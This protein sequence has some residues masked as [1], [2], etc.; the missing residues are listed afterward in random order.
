MVV[1]KSC[2]SNSIISP[3]FA[4]WDSSAMKSFSL[5]LICE[6]FMSSLISY[7]LM[8]IYFIHWLYKPTTIAIQ[9]D[10]P[11]CPDLVSGTMEAP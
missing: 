2:I 7:E 3:P 9:F 1:E 5:T 6:L 10:A 11:I 8:D 4:S